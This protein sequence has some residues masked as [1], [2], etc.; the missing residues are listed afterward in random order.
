MAEYLAVAE[1]N[2][3]LNSPVLFTASI[4]CRRGNIYH[5]DET[6]VFILRGN[7]N[8]CFARYLVDFNGNAEI[9]EDG[10]V[11]PI[12]LAI[13]ENGEPRQS[14]KSIYT[15]AA[16]DEFGNLTA[17]AIVTVPKGCCFTV[18]VR[19]VDAPTD[20]ATTEPTPLITVA[21]ANLRITRIA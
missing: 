1:Q 12:A 10:G 17:T 6:G 20:D 11:T 7:T 2:V 8:S 21:N 15:P 19:Y 9:P 14:S 13:T 18:S 16:V 4:P 5:E 3:A